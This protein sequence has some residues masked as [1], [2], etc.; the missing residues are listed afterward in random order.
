MNLEEVSNEAI[1]EP[2]LPLSNRT[3]QGLSEFTTRRNKNKDSSS[4]TTTRLVDGGDSGPTII[5]LVGDDEQRHT[6]RHD[7]LEIDSSS[8]HDIDGGGSN[9]NSEKVNIQA[10]ILM[11]AYVFGFFGVLSVNWYVHCNCHI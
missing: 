1:Q 7:I 6:A 10:R 8:D 9:N 11:I 5:H 3:E 4:E 2:L